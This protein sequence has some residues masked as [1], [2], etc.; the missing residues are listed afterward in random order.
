[1]GIRSQGGFTIIETTL[2]LA[3]TSVLI[4]AIIAGAGA[5]LNN[6]RYRDSV[7]SFKSLVQQQYTNLANVQNGRTDNWSCAANGT[8]TQ[9]G[10]VTEIRGQSN[11]F[12]LGKY[13][14]IDRGD[15]TIYTLVGSQVATPG[16]DDVASLTTSYAINASTTEIE[17]RNLEWGS[18]IAW[19]TAGPVDTNGSQT[20]RQLGILFI[21]SPNSG[22]IYTFTS[23]TV[24]AKDAVSRTTINAMIVAGNAVPGQAAR[25]V[26]IDS[27]GV[28]V[29]GG[30]GLY[31][32]SYASSVNAVEAR[33]NQNA[34]SVADGIKC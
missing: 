26:C 20:P 7:E 13:M 11:C 24:P 14:R 15:V 25:M 16:A 28:F 34:K 17:D 33:T 12:L 6:Q 9:G 4:L 10:P 22:Q 32:T 3:V 31:L 21:R 5:S 1:M 29:D 19:A 30:M 23:N 27:G 8:V 18:E 2:F